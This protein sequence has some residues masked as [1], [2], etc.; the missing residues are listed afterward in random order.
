MIHV[1]KYTLYVQVV[2]D[3]DKQ[4]FNEGLTPLHVAVREGHT[5]CA[6]CLVGFGADLAATDIRGNTPLHLV[7]S[8]K[9]MKPLSESTPHL[10]EV[11]MQSFNCKF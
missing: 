5:A 10:N 9:N 6:E 7:L 3:L 11:S 1:C 4:T 8:K 2:A